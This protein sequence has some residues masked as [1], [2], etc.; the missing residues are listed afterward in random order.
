MGEAAERAG[1]E[2]WYWDL[3]RGVAVPASQRRVASQMLGPYASRAEAERWH[4]TVEQRNEAWDDADDE[5][6]D[7][8]G[9][10]D[11]DG[12]D[13]GDRSDER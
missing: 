9:D 10:D 6:N 7:A 11:R 5:W 4:D 13:G 3:Q 2:Q 1:D 8:W 12:G